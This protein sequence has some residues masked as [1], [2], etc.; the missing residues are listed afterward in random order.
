LKGSMPKAVTEE[1]VKGQQI[2]GRQNYEELISEINC[3]DTP[4]IWL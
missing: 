2:W 3:H 4:T 1:F